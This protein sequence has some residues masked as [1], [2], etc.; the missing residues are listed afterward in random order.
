[1]V[2]VGEGGNHDTTRS[3]LGP[4]RTSCCSAVDSMQG[5]SPVQQA[6]RALVKV[7]LALAAAYR[8]SVNVNRDSEDK[9]LHAAYKKFALKVH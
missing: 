8:V 5:C 1:M 7:L 6:K 2:G 3:H 9:A 4:S